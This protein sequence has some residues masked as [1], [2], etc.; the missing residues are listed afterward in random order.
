MTRRPVYDDLPG[1]RILIEIEVT[2]L[3]PGRD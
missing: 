2:A 1:K 3:L